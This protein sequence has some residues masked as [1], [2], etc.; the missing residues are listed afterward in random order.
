MNWSSLA[1]RID[2]H[3]VTPDHPGYDQARGG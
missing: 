2:G 3:L 1:A